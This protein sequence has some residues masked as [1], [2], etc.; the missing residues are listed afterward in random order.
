MTVGCGLLNLFSNEGKLVSGLQR[1]NVWPF[2]SVESH[3][4]GMDPFCGK[5]NSDYYSLPEDYYCK[6][7]LQ[8]DTYSG[9]VYYTIR[10]ESLLKEQQIVPMGD[11][12]VPSEQ[13]TPTNDELVRVNAILMKDP[14]MALE[15]EEKALIVKSKDYLKEIPN[16]LTYYLCS[17]RW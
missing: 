2:C 15:Q 7:D 1:V 9:D 10:D 14:L 16:T 17:V 8:F 11:K 4:S 3:F 12:A 6:L 5:L 13:T